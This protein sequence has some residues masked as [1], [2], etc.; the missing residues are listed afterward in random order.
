MLPAWSVAVTCNCS[1]S[2]CGGTR[3]MLNAPLAPATALPSTVVPSA[4]ST[5][6]VLPG[7]ARP[8]ST[9]PSALM[10]R[11]LGWAGGSRSAEVTAPGAET[12]PAASV[13]STCTVLPSTSAGW[14]VRWKVPS[15]PTVPV[16]RTLPSASRTCT[17]VPASPRPLS[18]LPAWSITRLVGA[19]GAVVSGGLPTPPS[20]AVTDAGSELFPAGSVRVTP[21]FSPLVCSE[22]SETS[23]V[24][25]APTVPVPITLPAASRT[26]TVVPASPRPVTCR[27]SGDT[28][29]SMALAGG[30]VSPGAEPPLL[31]PPLLWSAAAA[32]PPTPSRLRAAMAQVGVALPATPMPATS[33]SSEATSSKVNPVKAAAS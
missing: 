6:T 12:L 25:S 17:V 26:V 1:P 19:S 33:S 16:A 21:S 2:T 9:L 13:S 28:N 22:F 14:S 18:R 15:A 4:A 29:R 11:P 5:F 3:L 7:S 20:G 24:P 27:P 23:K 8:V 32:A 30:V 31:P 10:I